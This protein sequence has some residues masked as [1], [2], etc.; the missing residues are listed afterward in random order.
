MERQE[1]NLILSAMLLPDVPKT[2][3]DLAESIRN[4]FFEMYEKLKLIIDNITEEEADYSPAPEEW[5]IKEIIAHLIHTE[6]EHQIWVEN[7]VLSQL[8]IPHDFSENLTARVKALVA[9][10]PTIVELLDQLKK[11]IEESVLCYEFLPISAAEDKS[12]FWNLS[13][14]GN[15]LPLHTQSHFN[16]INN[17]LK[18]ARK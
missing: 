10:F 1:S 5:S 3:K 17:T 9:I 12:L 8:P 13:L 14:I 16:Q 6:R 18:L 7:L 11:S 2:P 15:E 4:Q